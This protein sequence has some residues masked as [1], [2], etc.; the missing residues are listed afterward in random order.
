MNLNELKFMRI[1]RRVGSYL[2]LRVKIDLDNTDKV[3]NSRH[4]AIY[5]THALLIDTVNTLIKNII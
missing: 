2:C 3:D 5:S 1:K 4:Y